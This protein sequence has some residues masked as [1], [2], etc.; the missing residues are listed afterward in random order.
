MNKKLSSFFCDPKTTVKNAALFLLMIFLVVYA[1]FQI[2]P[3]FTQ[4]IEVETALLVSVYDT[5]VTTGYIFR[6]EEVIQST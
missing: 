6:D 4:S 1:F 2:L 5:T 3:T